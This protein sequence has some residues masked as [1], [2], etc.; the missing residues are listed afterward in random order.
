MQTIAASHGVRQKFISDGAASGELLARFAAMVDAG[1]LAVTV[2][3]VLPLSETRQ[4][5][6]M[7]QGKHMRGKLVLQVM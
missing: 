3:K 4:A 5:H 7:V 2:S 6:E 1:Q